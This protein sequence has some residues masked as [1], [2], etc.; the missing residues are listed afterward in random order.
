MTVRVG[1]HNFVV[2]TYLLTCLLTLGALRRVDAGEII[3]PEAS[4]LPHLIV[5]NFNF[6]APVLSVILRGP[7]FTLGVLHSVDAP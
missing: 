2:L 6:L 4:T 7:K 5:F 1:E 3:V